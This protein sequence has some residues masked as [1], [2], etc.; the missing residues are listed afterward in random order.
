[1]RWLGYLPYSRIVGY[2][3]IAVLFALPTFAFAGEKPPSVLFGLLF[4][5]LV[6][7]SPIWASVLAVLFGIWLWRRHK[8]GK[9][10]GALEQ[11]ADTQPATPPLPYTNEEAQL[12]LRMNIFTDKGQFRFG[13]QTY[14]SLFEALQAAGHISDK[15]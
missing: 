5:L 14:G 6:L 15:K 10:A 4:A 2:A 1:M 13:G 9:V 8:R 11:F 3:Q 7:S 12:M